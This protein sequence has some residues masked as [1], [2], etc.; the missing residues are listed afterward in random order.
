[1]SGAEVLR[2]SGVGSWPEVGA[3][4]AV[5]VVRDLLGEA[6]GG[7]PYVPEQPGRGP[8]AD[9]VGRAG[10]MLVEMSVDLQ[11]SGWRLTDGVGRD[12]GRARGYL[13]EDLDETAEAYDGY[14]GPLKTQVCGPWTLASAL[15]LPRGDL[16]LSDRGAARD[17]AQSLTAGVVDHVSRLRAVVP[18]AEVIV[19]LDEPSLPAALAGELHTASGFSRLRALDRGVAQD[20]LAH[21]VDELRGVGSRVVFHC[22]APDAPLEMFRRAGVDGV[23]LDTS[24]IDERDFEALGELVDSGIDLWAGLVP[25]DTPERHP[26]VHVEAFRRMWERVG[27][28][29]AEFDRVIVTPACGLAGRKPAGAVAAQRLAID[30]SAMLAEA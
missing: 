3:R 9:M 30:A 20:V 22:C 5:R 17:L 14:A 2:V 19:Q 18:G 11:P 25:T 26:R 8:G 28:G 12:V 7:I 23:S 29:P 4:E 15:W 1:M 10:G 16:V 27:F 6:P 13:R 21:M 24:L